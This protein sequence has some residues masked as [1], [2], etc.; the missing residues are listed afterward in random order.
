LKSDR[1]LVYRNSVP[2]SK[3]AENEEHGSD[4]EEDTDDSK[5]NKSDEDEVSSEEMDIDE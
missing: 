3:P 1:A 4:T 5:E 2:K